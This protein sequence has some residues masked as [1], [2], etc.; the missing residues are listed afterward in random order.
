MGGKAKAERSYC[1]N[2]RNNVVLDQLG[3]SGD[4]EKRADF[5]IF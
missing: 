4:G 1:I 2:L 5:D 3:D